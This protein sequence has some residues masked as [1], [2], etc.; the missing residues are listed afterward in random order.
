MT[1]NRQTGISRGWCQLF[2]R[3]FLARLQLPARPPS[4]PTDNIDVWTRCEQ[5]HFHLHAAFCSNWETKDVMTWWIAKLLPSNLRSILIVVTWNLF[6]LWDTQIF[7]SQ[8]RF[9]IFDW[10]MI[11]V[12]LNRNTTFKNFH[13]I[14]EVNHEYCSPVWI[15]EKWKIWSRKYI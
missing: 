11:H 6:L 3:S 7:I 14:A 15:H 1:L 13:L 10:I 4:L 9:K 2:A 8:V 12:T 5:T